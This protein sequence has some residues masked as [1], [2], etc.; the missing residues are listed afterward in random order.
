[1]SQKKAK[2]LR[3]D[4]GK[5]VAEFTITAKGDGSVQVTGPFHNFLMFREI[6]CKAEQAVIHTIVKQSQSKIVVPDMKIIN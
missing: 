3:K 6:M 2:K 5:I 1:M 4:A